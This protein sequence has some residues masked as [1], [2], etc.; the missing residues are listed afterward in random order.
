[1]NTEAVVIYIKY[2]V[3]CRNAFFSLSFAAAIRVG[4]RVREVDHYFFPQKIEFWPLFTGVCVG[5]K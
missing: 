1:M 3:R 5:Y 2:C 4:K